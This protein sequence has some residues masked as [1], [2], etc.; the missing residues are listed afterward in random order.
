MFYF[1]RKERLPSIRG[2]LAVKLPIARTLVVGTTKPVA[3]GVA[4][5]VD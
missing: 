2:S 4:D 3:P 1:Y 5:D